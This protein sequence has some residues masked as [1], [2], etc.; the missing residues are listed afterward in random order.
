M[1]YDEVFEIKRQ[2]IHEEALKS[3]RSSHARAHGGEE[4]AREEKSGGA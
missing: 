2:A 4:A 1:S 3:A